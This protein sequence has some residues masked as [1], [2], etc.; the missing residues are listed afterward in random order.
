[1]K[2]EQIFRYN[3]NQITF[4]NNDGNTMMNATEMAKP[5]GKK[6]KDFF[7][8][9]Q[10]KDFC[11]T[12]CKSKSLIIKKGDNSPLLNASDFS[13]AFPELVLCR[14]GSSKFGGGVWMQE[15]LALEFA[16]WLSP[17][18]HLWC[19]E[20]F[21]AMKVRICTENQDVNE[22]EEDEK[23]DAMVFQY[24][25]NQ[26]TFLSENKGLMVNATEMAKPFGK[27]TTNFLSLQQ[28]RELMLSLSAVT[29]IPV[30][31]LVI[32][33]Q[34][35][36][37]KMAQGTWMHE[38]LALIFAQW[39]SPDFY[40]WCNRRIKEI[41]FGEIH[42]PT[43]EVPVDSD[44]L[45]LAHALQLA[46]DFINDNLPRMWYPSGTN[47]IAPMILTDLVERVREH[48]YVEDL[49][50]AE[51]LCSQ[52]LLSK[53][54]D[55][56]YYPT[57]EALDSLLLDIRQVTIQRVDGKRLSFGLPVFTEQGL[58]RLESVIV[59]LKQ[60]QEILMNTQLFRRK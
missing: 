29:G 57:Q 34:G 13:E 50:V 36:N 56:F 5:F 1:M 41:L 46:T 20:C 19:K 55:G 8:I 59:P 42:H 11:I 2:N 35:G 4:L 48:V 15:D 22:Q 45:H 12:L 26:V 9:E 25:G 49:E 6:S 31:G 32:V 53:S 16:R 21:K 18:F 58:Q 10:S 39:L 40:L 27:R 30:T 3:G 24:Y 14:K 43:Q 17:N 38:D 44:K 7:K 33:N 23:N 51:Y 52:E 47:S 60:R 54:S 37:N 28:T